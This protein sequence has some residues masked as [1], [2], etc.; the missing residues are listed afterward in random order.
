MHFFFFF[1]C[2]GSLGSLPVLDE[3]SN[4]QMAEDTD[5]A[6]RPWFFED[7]ALVKKRPKHFSLNS[8]GGREWKKKCL[9]VK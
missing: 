1:K 7:E 5:S 9:W 8:A 3:M 2:R 6:A 4:F